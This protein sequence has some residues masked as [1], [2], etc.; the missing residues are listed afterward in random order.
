MPFARVCAL[1]GLCLIPLSSTKADIAFD[2]SGEFATYSSPYYVLACVKDFAMIAHL[3]IDSGGRGR[4][5]IDYTLLRPGLGGTVVCGEQS[6]K[7]LSASAKIS[8]GAAA[9]E[10]IPFDGATRNCRIEP[11]NE[12]SFRVRV[13]GGDAAFGGEFFQLSTS[14]ATAPVT[15]WA[16]PAEDEPARRGRWHRSVFDPSGHGVTWK[17][18][19]VLHFPDYG[20]VKVACDDP[21][22]TLH[23]EIIADPNEAGLSLGAFNRGHH[24][25]FRAYHHGTVRL[26]FR[27][28]PETSAGSLTFTVLEENYPRLAGCDFSEAKWNGLKRCW[29]N[30]FPMNPRERCMGDNILLNGIAHLS[31]AFKADMAVF[32][33]PLNAEDSMLAALGRALEASFSRRVDENDGHIR[34]YG[35]ETTAVCL[36]A[37][38]D[39][40]AAT[41]DWDLVRRN[42]PSIRRAVAYLLA[43]DVDGDGILEAPFHGNRMEPVS[44]RVTNWWDDFAFGHKDAYGNLMAHRALRGM[45][46]IFT[47]LELPADAAAIDRKLAAFKDAFHETFFNPA[48]GVYAG[49][50]SQDGKMHDYMF[51]FISA[52]A[53]N[54][55]LVEQELAREVLGKMLARMQELGYDGAYGVPGP[56]IPVDPA[57]KGDWEVHS[58]WGVYENGGL[59]GQTAYHFLQ[60]L[61]TVDMRQQ[62]DEILFKMLDTFEREPTHSGLFPGYARSVDW[63]TKG[64]APCGYNYLADNYYFLLTAVTGHYRVEFPP[65]GKPPRVSAPDHAAEQEQP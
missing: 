55:G 37:L 5:A 15:V 57:D 52:M 50:I 49:W 64:G 7:G 63:R 3:G 30:A 9:Y 8:K 65:L 29:Q 25:R 54:E 32:T 42:L 62:A 33:P 38:H 58:R 21:G 40:L 17:L 41:N 43:R 61:Y 35:W 36:I 31:M 28:S 48:T 53:I 46:E 18:P 51:T 26:G 56:L 22:A 27:A 19:A 12:R 4:R 20:L 60:A 47:L 23:Q 45:R 39:Y 6:S 34:G 1:L 13:Y 16:Q 14:P 59:C 11:V 44:G 24:T 10:D 2:D